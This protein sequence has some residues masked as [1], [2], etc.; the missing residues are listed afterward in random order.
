MPHAPTAAPDP[1]LATLAQLSARLGADPALIQAAGGNTS[2]KQPDGTLWVK[3]SGLWLRDARTRPM[4]VPV[5][6]AAVRAGVR[7]GLADPVGPALRPDAAATGL[8]A[9]IETTLHA[10]MPHAVVLHVHAVDAI[11]W[12]VLPPAPGE[13]LQGPPLGLAAALAAFRWTW[14]PY[15]RPGLDLTRA[16][17]A[18]LDAALPG[19]GPDVLL[20]ANHGLVVGGDTAEMAAGRLTGVVSALRR[21]LRPLPA[22]DTSALAALAQASDWALPTHARAHAIAADA[23]HLRRAQAGVLYPDHVVFLGDQLATAPCPP[24]AT[25]A[26]AALP[27]WAHWLAGPAHQAGP[28]G[29]RPPVVALPGLGVLVRPDL[30]EAAQEM[31]ACW[32]DVLRRLP[33]TPEPRCLPPAEAHALANWEA[34]KFRQQ[35]G[36]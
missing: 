33:D 10:L 34:E 9:S 19:Q 4:F 32:S 11:A 23:A 16:V 8:R 18:R 12:G 25:T 26:L 1:A 13:G 24:H 17:A 2:L 30:G 5:D 29:G 35:Q 14:V 22:V 36:R 20:L 28:Q 3:G 27:A 6:G 31:L 7:A 15:A 21:P